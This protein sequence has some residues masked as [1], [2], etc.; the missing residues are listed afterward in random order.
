[1][2]GPVLAL[3]A[4]LF[5]QTP[6][7]PELL[8]L[9]NL[10]ELDLTDLSS[11]KTY[12]WNKKQVPLENMA[13]HLRM[14]NAV[15]KSL[16]ELGYRPDTARPDVRVQYRVELVERLQG[17]ASQT[18]S[19]WDDA[20]STVQINFSRE[21]LANVS[22]EL[23]EAESN[24]LVWHAKGTYTIGTPDK[25]EKQINAAVTALF[26]QYPEESNPEE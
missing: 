25:A 2:I 23:V 5:V 11:Y 14:I 13:N 1:M 18:R 22:I 26:E 24:F 15:Q 20:N 16:K 6:H 19:V 12:A 7:K 10:N 9:P 8:Q 17:R 21:K 4:T 3:V